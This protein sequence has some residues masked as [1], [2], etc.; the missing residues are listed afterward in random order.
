MRENWGRGISVALAPSKAGDPSFRERIARYERLGVSPD[1]MVEGDRLS[2]LNDVRAL[3]PAISVPTLVVTRQGPDYVSP[4]AG[5]Y[6]AANVAGARYVGLPA[7]DQL[8]FVGDVDALAD[9]VEEFLT[10]SRE[11]IEGDVMTATILFTDIVSSTEQSARMGHRRWSALSADHNAMVRAVLQSFRGREVKT[12]G[13]GFLATFDATS[14]AL[15]A[16]IE[17]VRGAKAL[18]MDV[19]AGVHTGEIEVRPDDVAGLPVSIAKRICDLAGPGEVFVSRTVTEHVAGSGIEFVDRG[20]HHL[21]G[22]PDTWH[23]FAVAA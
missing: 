10:G 16:A 18:G 4:E 1:Q 5:R 23:L 12:I 14:R 2:C 19:R 11:G 21:K 8:F 20:A 9:E 15:R 22:V 13:D 17:I 6:I 7:A 3:L